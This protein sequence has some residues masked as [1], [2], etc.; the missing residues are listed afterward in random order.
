VKAGK[1]IK[2]EMREMKEGGKGEKKEFRV[3]KSRK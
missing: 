3:K 2:R 1:S